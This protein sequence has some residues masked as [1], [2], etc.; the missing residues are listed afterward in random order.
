[1]TTNN[2]GV[3]PRDL[4]QKPHVVDFETE[5]IE[6]RPA[7]PPKPVGVAIKEVGKKPVYL[8]WGHPKENNSTRADAIKRLKALYKSDRPIAFHNAKFDLDV[9]EVH[10]GLPLMPKSGYHD[11]SFLAFL[12]DPHEKSISLKPLAD[13]HLSMAPTEQHELRDWILDNVPEAKKSNWGAHIAKAPGKLV[14]KYAKGDVVRTLGLYE[15]FI[16]DVCNSGM[17]DAYIR[18][19]E[20]MPVLL[21]AERDGVK[22]DK[23]RLAFDVCAY[24]SSLELV[25]K[26]IRRC[27]GVGEN[28]N[29]GSSKQLGEA[30]YQ[31]DFLTHVI[32]TPSGEIAT[33]FEALRENMRDV[34]LLGALRYRARIANAVGTFMKPWL[35]MA[36]DSENSRIYTRYHQTVN[37]DEHGVP[38]R[39]GA[40]TGRLS[41]SPNF[42]NASKTPPPIF[43]PSVTEKERKRIMEELDVGECIVLPK[44]FLS[45][46]EVKQKLP[47]LR[48]YVIPDNKGDALIGRDYS[49]QELKI[50]GYYERGKLYQA[51]VDNPKLDTH[52]YAQE[53]LRDEFNL[54]L[55]RKP[56]KN[57]GF[58]LIYGMGPPTLA[59]KSQIPVP[60]AR[61][62]K[63]TYLAMFPGL[64]ELLNEIKT[65]AKN[66][67]P[68]Y[69]WGGRRYFVEEPLVKT[70]RVKDFYG[71]WV[72]QEE[73]R[74][75]E[76]KLINYL[77]Q[78]SAADNTKQALINMARVCE[79]RFRLTYHDET[80]RN[81]GGRPNLSDIRREHKIMDEAMAD[82]DFGEL[83]MS[84]DG[85]YGKTNWQE[86]RKLHNG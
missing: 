44:R 76:Y 47:Y 82:V 85:K 16:A 31:G 1:M 55:P 26:H 33:N 59:K 66:G 46:P 23:D 67:E 48:S 20:V 60:V 57:T 14:G 36:I 45:K 75:F 77:I 40:R 29:I 4:L 38:R 74:T 37:V 84:S 43:S 12:V 81:L 56:V 17:A 62:L 83:R 24:E 27:L 68:V 3:A 41:S 22:V 11:T 70:K 6:A 19:L 69:T 5:G 49:Q 42:Q 15:H 53:T 72:D 34:K 2:I 25:D 80:L 35:Q 78:G 58:G 65:A 73:K 28:F 63:K 52:R 30:L 9:G 13:K 54:D 50:L 10:L 32:E 51:Y 39:F 79:S 7:Y 61:K 21:D 71:E 86:M 64:D 18:E 8:A